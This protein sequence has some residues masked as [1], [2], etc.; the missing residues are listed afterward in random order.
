MVLLCSE[1][2]LH[3]SMKCFQFKSSEKT[4]AI[5][6]RSKNPQIVQKWRGHEVHGLCRDWQHFGTRHL[7]QI[8]RIG[9]TSSQW[10]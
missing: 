2:Q 7:E 4:P 10:Q 3:Q 8:E 1:I 6:W 9:W 5:T